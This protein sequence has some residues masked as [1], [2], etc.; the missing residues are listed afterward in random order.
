M[1]QP[2]LL[3]L[4]GLE[5]KERE[6][7]YKLKCG[8]EGVVAKVMDFPFHSKQNFLFQLSE[9]RNNDSEWVVGDTPFQSAASQLGYCSLWGLS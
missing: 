6:R 2:L 4:P 1:Y 7:Q 9:K 8:V 5:K 3:P